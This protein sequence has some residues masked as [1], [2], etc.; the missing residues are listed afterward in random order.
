[1]VWCFRCVRNLLGAIVA[2][3]GLLALTEVGLRIERLVHPVAQGKSADA[4]TWIRPSAVTGWELPP[5]TRIAVDSE[6]GPAV[7]WRTNSLGL[8][9]DE[10]TVPKPVGTYRVVVLGDDA[11]LAPS[12]PDEATVPARIQM[13]LQ[14]VSPSRVEVV[15]A[16]LPQA[17]PET[18]AILYRQ[19]LLA[20]QPDVV[21]L[22]VH[23]H[24]IA[25][26]QALRKW[27]VR[28]PQGRGLVC[29]HPERAGTPKTLPV[30]HLR[31]EFA[32]LDR[33]CKELGQQWDE[34][35]PHRSRPRKL[36]RSAM[37]EMLAPIDTLV[38]LCQAT[39]TTFV[40]C[41]AP[42]SEAE[43][44]IALDDG[45]PFLKAA[46]ETIA[47]KRIPVIDG[48]TVLRSRDDFLTSAP[49]WTAAGQAR[50]ADLLASQIVQNLRGPWSQP[51]AT[52]ETQPV[53]H[54][55]PAPLPRRIEV[56]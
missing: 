30:A 37:D 8:R 54:S 47:R 53:S 46:F 17:V 32:V 26:D 14:S 1:M 12:S 39:A 6:A 40:V 29:I 10:I 11:I 41:I 25:E 18:A 55:Q 31:H 22:H 28:D 34:P 36:T 7:V 19:R 24:Q 16:A 35:T 52:P 44:P 48:S 9:G 51:Y 49:G 27:M 33:L 15:N 56:R 13:R 4:D 21:I 5:A 45:T 20:L 42:T 38:T 23:A 50:L 43:L 3:A 2:L